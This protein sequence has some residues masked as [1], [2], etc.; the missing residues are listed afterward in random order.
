MVALIPLSLAASPAT[1]RQDR[2]AAVFAVGFDARHT[3]QADDHR[4]VDAHKAPGIELALD[5]RDR[6][7]FQIALAAGMQGDVIVLRLDVIELVEGDDVDTRAIAHHDAVHALLASAGILMAPVKLE[8]VAIL[9]GLVLANLFAVDFL[10]IR[11]FQYF[12]LH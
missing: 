8:S 11:I 7:R 5:F 4:A 2:Q 6:L 12:D 9:L 1:I 3:L 10:K